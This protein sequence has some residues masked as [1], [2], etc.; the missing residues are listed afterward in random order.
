MDFFFKINKPEYYLTESKEQ[1]SFITAKQKVKKADSGGKYKRT[2]AARK[3]NTGSGEATLSSQ[4]A[5]NLTFTRYTC[6]YTATLL[7]MVTNLTHTITRIFG[8]IHLHQFFFFFWK[9]FG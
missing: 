8:P 2:I 6:T 9:Y 3:P 1:K 7:Y 5:Y 4:Q